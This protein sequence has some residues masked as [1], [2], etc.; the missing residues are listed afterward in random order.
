MYQH[1]GMDFGDRDILSFEIIN[2]A[3][4]HSTVIIGCT[5]TT[6]FPQLAN[7]FITKNNE[8]YIFVLIP[9]IVS[10]IFG[11]HEVE[12]VAKFAYNSTVFI[13]FFIEQFIQ[14]FVF[15]SEFTVQLFLGNEVR[16]INK[17][18]LFFV[19]DTNLDIVSSVCLFVVVI[20]HR[21]NSRHN[22]SFFGTKN[23]SDVFVTIF[24]EIQQIIM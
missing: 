24:R 18:P 6:C 8:I 11:S 1:I 12:L 19:E 17:F 2:Q 4:A 21:A 10:Q 14:K 5:C 20:Y 3:V 22:H 16:G 23:H 9:K 13:Q 7:M 15:D